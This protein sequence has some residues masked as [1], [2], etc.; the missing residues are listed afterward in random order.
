MVPNFQREFEWES[1]DIRE[2]MRSIF[3][4]Y[5]IGSLLLWKGKKENFKALSCEAILVSEESSRAEHIV[6]DGQQRLTA[7]YYAFLAPEEALPG[8]ANRRIYYINVDRF[9]AG[10][11][12]EAFHHEWRPTRIR[13]LLEN[14]EVQFS[15]HIFPLSVIGDR[16]TNAAL[17]KWVEAY[18][19]YWQKI[20]ESSGDS[21]GPDAAMRRNAA[22]HAEN[23]DEFYKSMEKI[24]NNYQIPYIELDQ[25]LEINKICDIFAQIN[26]RGVRLNIFDLLNAL[27]T[28]KLVY[29]KDMKRDAESRIEFVDPKKLGVYILQIMSIIRQDYCSPKYLYYLL[30]G[31]KKLRRETNR[32]EILIRDATDFKERWQ[33][34]VCAL[35]KAVAMLRHPQEFGAISPKYLPYSSILPVFSALQAYANNCEPEKRLA[36]KRKIRLWYWAS[37]FTNQYSGAVESTSASDYRAIRRWIEEIEEDSQG[38]ALIR[39]FASN[40]RSLN[41][42]GE[43]KPGTSVY[44][45][46]FNLLILHPARDWSSGEVPQPGDLDDHHIVPVSWGKDNLKKNLVH[47][48]LNRTP[49]SAETNRDVIGGKLP[50][51]YLPKLMSKMGEDEVIAILES[52]F[53]S[54]RAINILRNDPFDSTHFEEFVAERQRTILDGIESLLVKERLELPVNL[55]KLDAAVEKIELGLRE[56]IVEKLE[57]NPKLLPSDIKNAAEE[58]IQR[59][60]RNNP[61]MNDDGR[62]NTLS[63]ILEFCDLRGLQQTIMNKNLSGKFQEILTNKETLQTRF[64]QLAN[65]RNPLRHSRQVDNV[66]RKEGEAAISWFGRVLRISDLP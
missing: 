34:A 22:S 38:P 51:E 47:T 10:D 25:D 62:Y 24:V 41:L 26:S 11:H 63:G 55:R 56:L 46:I 35:E 43:I 3:L 52:H 16:R 9:M 59:A 17:Y 7:L 39:E 45:G 30:P 4:D 14:Q 48:V 1:S 50:N 6:L 18:K 27:L 53:I 58:N 66:T 5:Y 8:T 19:D 15:E 29:L 36:A 12:D 21:Q 60:E 33:Q 20:A 65:L 49:L 42:R 13:R 57:N 37:V 31:E 64:R 61:A 54:R 23:A 32:K 2:L 28:P 44:N 40:F